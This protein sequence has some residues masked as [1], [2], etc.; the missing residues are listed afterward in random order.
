MRVAT[1]L[2]ISQRFKVRH[3]WFGCACIAVILSSP[4]IV[5]SVRA[6]DA[7]S[8]GGATNGRD[9]DLGSRADQGK[10]RD[11]HGPDNRRPVPKPPRKWDPN[12][13]SITNLP[14]CGGGGGGGGGFPPP[15]P[16]PP[17]PFP[18]EDC[19]DI[20][21]CPSKEPHGHKPEPEDDPTPPKPKPEP[22]PDPVP[23]SLPKPGPGTLNQP[24]PDP[25]PHPKPLPAPPSP[26]PPTQRGPDAAV[27]PEPG[28]VYPD[29]IPVPVPHP[30]PYPHPA[31]KPDRLRV[32]PQGVYPDPWPV[33]A[34]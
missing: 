1:P 30:M 19:T 12:P 25:W 18:P 10:S 26:I 13:C 32:P 28:G 6:S 21:G 5:S 20:W 23:P 14:A 27:V 33:P 7:M 24:L 15:S 3:A 11:D 22:L 8:E 4:A 29:P 31:P 16:I 2:V 17:G 34:P 9:S